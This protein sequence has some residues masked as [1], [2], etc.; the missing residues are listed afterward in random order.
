MDT[1]PPRRPTQ[2]RDIVLHGTAFARRGVPRGTLRAALDQ[3]RT[4][5]RREENGDAHPE[6]DVR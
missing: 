6:G 5:P 1:L 2:T 4:S 3:T